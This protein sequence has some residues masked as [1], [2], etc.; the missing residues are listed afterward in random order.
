MSSR[1]WLVI[2]LVL[3]STSM[4]CTPLPAQEQQIPRELA[5][6]LIP[7]GATEGGEIIVGQL[8]ADIASDFVLPLGG[9]VLGSFVS[10]A[11]AQA[12]VT[13]PGSADS[14]AAFARR[15]LT[16][17]GWVPRQPS[18]PRMGGLQY[19]S[20]QTNVPVTFCKA[21][22]PAT[23]VVSTQYHG[24]A[25]LLRLTRN[26]NSSICDSDLQRSGALTSS[27]SIS[28]GTQAVTTMQSR[29]AEMPLASVPPLYAPTDL[30][31]S[32]SCRA[33]DAAMMGTQSQNQ[34]LKTDLSM[35]DILAYYA[36]QLDSAG[37]KSA[38]PDSSSVA[39][40]WANATTGQE[41]TII[42]SQ[43]P[44]QLGCYEVTLRATAARKAK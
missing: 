22:S 32:Q 38:I 31:R 8:P 11:Y 12:V 33:I 42:I 34:P 26:M 23:M 13:I 7:Y 10:L 41:V 15:S 4:P 16:D 17:H 24:P 43:M 3:V 20:P 35:R 1:P 25:T 29:M 37:W 5:L 30:R 21:G 27:A 28:F 39:G 44:A 40:T 2:A 6:A 9:R 18:I 36:R 19:A 14:A